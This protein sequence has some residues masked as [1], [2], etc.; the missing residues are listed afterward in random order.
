MCEKFI[1]KGYHF[2]V[3]LATSQIHTCTKTLHTHLVPLSS[4]VNP[5]Y[6]TRVLLD[7]KPLSGN[8]DTIEFVTSELIPVSEFVA[9]SVIDVHGNFVR[10]RFPID[11]TALLSDTA[12]VPISIPD[13][14]LDAAIRESLELAEDSPITNR[15]M[16]SLL[17]LSANT[18]EIKDLTGLEYALNLKILYMRNNQIVDLTP[19]TALKNIRSLSL[20]GNQITDVNPLT[21]LTRLNILSLYN[22]QITHITPLAGLTNLHELWFGRNPISDITPL[23]ELTNVYWLYLSD[24]QISDITSLAK[25]TDL[26]V[27]FLSNNQITDVT[28]LAELVN[29]Q[30][31]YLDGNQV[32]NRKPLLALLQKNPDMKIYLKLGVALPVTL[33]YFR[34]EHTAAGVVLKWTTESEIDNAGFYILR[35]ETKDG[36]FKVVNPKLIQGAGTT[37]ERNEYTWTDSTAKPNT[38]YYYQIEDVSHAGDRKQLATVRLRGLVSASGK[39][40]TRWAGLKAR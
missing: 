16:H 13:V 10:R 14:N 20:D 12:P 18:S 35:S 4:T 1:R 37:G 22:N 21:G 26:R 29:L 11:M 27:L 9:L 39:F 5:I 24:N 40:T 31:L 23:T 19:L 17:I 8:S 38:V 36:E 34:A 6:A 7:C 3:E 15:D 30:K 33:S 2:S 32:K 28:P 25:L